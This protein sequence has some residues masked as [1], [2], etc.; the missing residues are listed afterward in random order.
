MK[1]ELSSRQAGAFTLLEL[2]LVITIIAIL[3]GLLLPAIQKAKGRARRVQCVNNLKE[4]GVAFHSFAHD[5]DGKFPMQVPTNAGGSLEFLRAATNAL[6]STYF[7]FRHFQALS[8]DLVTPRIL[9]CPADTRAVADNFRDLKNDQV[10]YFAGA[11]AEFDKPDSILAGDR[12]ITSFTP[13]SG[14][15][16]RLDSPNAIGWTG[17]LH[18][19]KGNLLFADGRVEELNG[20]GLQAALQQSPGKA[21]LFMPPTPAPGQPVPSNSGGEAGASRA[22]GG[23]RTRLEDF[24]RSAPGGQGSAAG[25]GRAASA[26]TFET[27]TP[28]LLAGS[29]QSFASVAAT[30]RIARPATNRVPAARPTPAVAVASP[31]LPGRANGGATTLTSYLWL[32]LLLGFLMVAIL[33]ASDAWRRHRRRRKAARYQV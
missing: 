30:N 2:L 13:G 20:A 17:D 16:V 1:T 33:T 32:F 29:T 6:G 28:T 5:H 10:S 19:Y 4:M 8:N 14:T 26:R 11:A 15:V 9:I 23:L 7:A 18:E 3:A 12:N 22:A 25:P 27:P 24:P 21:N 31:V